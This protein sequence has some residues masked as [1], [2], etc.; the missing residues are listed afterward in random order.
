MV[1][2]A[3][4]KITGSTLN[5]LQRR[6]TYQTLLG[7][8]QQM[9]KQAAAI[10]IPQVI[11]PK[12]VPISLIILTRIAVKNPAINDKPQ[13]GTQDNRDFISFIFIIFYMSIGND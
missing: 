1:Q 11:Y 4:S 3:E 5:M 12:L 13:L 2:K 8:F 6:G 9:K 10:R 7:S